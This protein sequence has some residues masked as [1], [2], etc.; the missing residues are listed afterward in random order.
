MATEIYLGNPPQHVIDW[1]KA[2]SKPTVKAE[3]HIKFTDETEGEYLIEGVMDCPALVAAGLMPEGSGTI[4]RPSWIKSPLEVEIGSAVTNIG[5]NVFYYCL[6]LTSVT[7]PSSVTSI[8]DA[9]F[10]NCSGLTSVTIPS[11]VTNIGGNAFGGCSGLTSVTIPSS[12]TNIG[13]NAFADCSGLTSIIVKGKTTTEARTL[14][15]NA[16]VY[17]INIIQGELPG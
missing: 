15:A 11:S 3:T 6:S 2:H 17:D 10:I 4:A 13:V 9:A 16:G 5:E 1:I 12:V 8:E 14:L 7:I